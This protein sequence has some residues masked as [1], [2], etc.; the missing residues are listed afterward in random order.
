MVVGGG[1]VVEN[2]DD[3]H[4]DDEIPAMSASAPGGLG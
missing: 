4:K 3:R 2:Y 1:E